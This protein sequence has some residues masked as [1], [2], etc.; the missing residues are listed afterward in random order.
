MNEQFSLLGVTLVGGKK[1]V[2]I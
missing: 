2:R 1:A